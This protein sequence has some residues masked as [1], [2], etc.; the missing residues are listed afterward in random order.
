MTSSHRPQPCRPNRALADRRQLYHQ[1][2]RQNRGRD[3]RRRNQPWRSRRARRMRPLCPLWRDPGSHPRRHRGNAASR[4]AGPGPGGPAGRH[5]AGRGPQRARL[6]AMGPRGQGPRGPDPRP[7]RLGP[8]RPYRAAGPR[9]RLHHLARVAAGH[10]G[11]R[12]RGRPPAAAQGQAR[13]RG[14][15]GADRG[16]APGRAGIRTHRRCQRGVDG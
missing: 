9:H 15:R 4:G 8:G 11:G 13:R 10:G 16:G 12:R 1:P 6:R 5:A 14:R 2:R 7:A 3:G